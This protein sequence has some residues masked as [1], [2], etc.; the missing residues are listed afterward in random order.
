MHKK[1]DSLTKFMQFMFEV[2]TLR[3]VLRS[4]R[5]TLLTDD[6]SDNIA[7][8]SY[9]VAMIGYLLAKAEKAKANKVVLMCLVHDISEAR[10]GDQNWVYKKYVRV[11]ENEIMKDQLEDLTQDNELLQ[12]AQEYERRRSKEAKIAK[13]AD[14]LDQVFL[15]KE[16]ANNG[17]QEASEWLVGREQEK[18]MYSSTAKMIAQKVRGNSVHCWWDDLWT[19][20]RR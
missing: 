3:K 20:D 8:H 12:I 2:G 6:L 16:Y 15:L 13:D 5:Q 7:S 19:A 11:F 18:R 10:S 14:L 1:K 17:N 4:H 9:R